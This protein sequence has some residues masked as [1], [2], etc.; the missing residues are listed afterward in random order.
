MKSRVHF[1]LLLIGC[2]LTFSGAS[3]Q[4][5]GEEDLVRVRFSTVS[6][7][8]TIRDL[9]YFSEGAPNP[10]IV[11]NGAPGK[12]YAYRGPRDLVFYTE[13]VG[14]EGEPVFTPR[15]SVSITPGEPDLL[16]IFLERPDSAD[17]KVLPVPDKGKEFRAGCFHFQNLTVE[18]V[19]LRVGE[20]DLLLAPGEG[21]TVQTPVDRPQNVDVQ[22]AAPS[23]NKEWRLVYQSRWGPPGNR[24]IWVFLHRSEEGPPKIKRYY[25]IV[26]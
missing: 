1:F 20:Q 23:E 15:A 10:I 11:A 19:A 14:P 7:D 21:Q 6:W 9:L 26:E 25:E 24:R 4:T 22:I 3:A 18:R 5:E 2:A 13:S 17:F 16:L 8:N 12:K